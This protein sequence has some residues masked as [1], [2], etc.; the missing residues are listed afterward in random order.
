MHGCRGRSCTFDHR[1]DDDGAC[2][3]ATPNIDNDGYD[4]TACGGD[5]CN[6]SVAGIHPYGTESCA[7]G[8]DSIDE[9]CRPETFQNDTTMDGDGDD[10]KQVSTLCFNLAPDGTH[11]G[12]T[13]CQDD[14]KLTYKGA[15]EECDYADNDCDGVIDE[16]NTHEGP[17]FPRGLQQAVFYPDADQ[18][19]TGNHEAPALYRCAGDAPLGYVPRYLPKD[20]DDGDIDINIDSLELCDG[21]GQRLLWFSSTTTTRT[22]SRSSSRSFNWPPTT[23]SAKFLKAGGRPVLV[24]TDCPGEPA[25]LIYALVLDRRP[26]RLHRR[27]NDRRGLSRL[28]GND[29]VFLLRSAGFATRLSHLRQLRPKFAR[30]P[31]KATSR[32]GD[33]GAEAASAPTPTAQ[34]IT[35]SSAVAAPLGVR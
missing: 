7:P 22:T 24:I 12:G 28:R 16:G 6:D 5:D 20:C 1:C 4:S 35:R 27:R 18:D 30:G 26:A 9:D 19:G 29:C 25:R 34:R 17:I 11:F 23:S 13:D 14:E 32:A 2:E 21:Q 3:C 31:R 15:K 10:D 8:G 33:E